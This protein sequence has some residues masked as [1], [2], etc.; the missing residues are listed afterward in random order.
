MRY[1]PP[2]LVLLALFVVLALLCWWGWRRRG[3]RDERAGL[4]APEAARPPSEV[5]AGPLPGT[6]V[7]T[8]RAEQ[9]LERVTAHG[10][11]MRSPVEVTV[12]EDGSWLLE[13]T[14]APSLTIRSDQVE[15]ITTAPGMVGK[16]IGGDGLLVIRWRLGPRL[17]DTGL[18]LDRR[19]DHDRLLALGP[20]VAAEPK[21]TR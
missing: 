4:P 7:A 13:R 20:A 15:G 5:R 21:E 8:A 14:G 1:V 9:H 19:E 10:L 16:W 3:R 17:L 11:G 18:R 6:Y 12:G 2:I